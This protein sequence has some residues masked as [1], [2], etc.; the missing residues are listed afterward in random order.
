MH[1]TSKPTTSESL[2]TVNVIQRYLMGRTLSCYML[3]WGVVVLCIGFTQNF[4]QL[5]TLR[6]LQGVFE[7]SGIPQRKMKVLTFPFKCCISPG[8]ILVIGSWYTTREHASR[9][10]VFQSANAG[11]GVIANLI[12]YG[13]GSVQKSRPDFQA[14]RYMSYVRF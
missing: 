3:C 7:V 13:I 14:W 2:L 4:K 8:F 10:L 12:L 11:F 5:V 9:S 1:P 6:A